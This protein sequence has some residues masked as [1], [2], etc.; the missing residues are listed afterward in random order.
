MEANPALKLPQ[1]C[2][3]AEYHVDC[4]R[5]ETLGTVS[6][7]LALLQGSGPSSHLSVV[8]PDK[9]YQIITFVTVTFL[10]AGYP[11][12]VT[13]AF[14]LILIRF[15][16]I[17]PR[18]PFIPASLSLVLSTYHGHCWVHL[19]AHIV[20]AMWSTCLEL[21]F[22]IPLN[23]TYSLWP[24]ITILDCADLL[25]LVIILYPFASECLLVCKVWVMEA[26]QR[27][28]GHEPSHTE[29]G[30]GIKTCLKYSD[31]W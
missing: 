3:L 13:L 29:S 18:Q 9:S 15:H 4:C 7:F 8:P 28:T 16:P 23:V 24:A 12:L 6:Q 2:T 5:V 31:V 25:L 26:T 1:S 14:H 30:T 17:L 21:T 19:S 27:H 11:L 22:E 10:L 20:I